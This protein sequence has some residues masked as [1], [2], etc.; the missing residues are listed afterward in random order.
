[1]ESEEKKVSHTGG[2]DKK[3][4]NQGHIST[5]PVFWA[6]RRT[7]KV[8]IFFQKQGTFLVT[9]LGLELVLE[10]MN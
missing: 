10:N 5:I 1:M 7:E 6:I 4:D 2:R 8:D 3:K 9:N